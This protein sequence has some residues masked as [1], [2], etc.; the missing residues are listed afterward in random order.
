MF[1]LHLLPS[2][3]SQQREETK[4]WLLF[5]DFADRLIFL[6]LIHQTWVNVLS[7]TI[8][9]LV[10]NPPEEAV[11]SNLPPSFDVSQYK[12]ARHIIDCTEVFW[13]N[14]NNLEVAALTWSDY[15]HHNTAKFLFSTTPSGLINFVSECWGGRTQW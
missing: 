2:F 5:Q 1:V 8:G 15:K 4:T 7:S 10:F 13:E 3:H 6:W 12:N 9:T 14:P 11:L